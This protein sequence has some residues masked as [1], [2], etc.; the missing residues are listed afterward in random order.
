MDKSF[1]YLLMIN[2]ALFSKKVL[3][4]LAELELTPGQPKVLDY[5]RLHDG[6]IQKDIAFGCMIEPA[7]LTGILE[8]MEEKDL[9][10]KR[11]INGNRRTI[12]VYLTDEG[13]M[14]ANKVSQVFI[15]VE[16]FV[17]SEIDKK[18]QEQFINVFY[19]ISRNMTETE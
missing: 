1:H 19:K 12:F 7:T 11:T 5:L 15:E 13:R 9:I 14:K 3:T 10:E 16:K 6:S 18:D 8:R 4:E 2:H 17:F